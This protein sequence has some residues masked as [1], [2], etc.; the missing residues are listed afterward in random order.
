MAE[1]LILIVDD[2]KP[3]VD[4]LKFNLQKEGFETIEAYDGATGL[5]LAMEKNPDLILL[6]VMLPEMDGFTVCKEI[7]VKS[8]VPIILLTAREEEVDKVL[9]LELG[10]DDYITKPYSVREL[11]ARIKANLRRT[12]KTQPVATSDNADV[13]TFG[14]LT[15]DT[16]RFEVQ[17]DGKPVEITVREFELLKFLAS[18]PDKIF[19]REKLLEKVWKYEYYG[20]LRTVDVTVRRLR[21]KLEDNPGEPDFVVTKRGIGYYFNKNCK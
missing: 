6:D 18:Q 20:D 11:L 9:G 15:I 17:K 12:K 21:E 10:A 5:Q 7:R 2:E 3:I 16:E 13:L 8:Q 19:S 1:R 14:R 4:I